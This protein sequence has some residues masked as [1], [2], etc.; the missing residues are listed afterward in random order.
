MDVGVRAV[1]TGFQEGSQ[2]VE[3]LA[4]SIDKVTSSGKGLDQTSTQASK[5]LYELM[6]GG[7][8]AMGAMR[9]LSA[10][11]MEA[12]TIIGAAA[13]VGLV[14]AIGY[15][16]SQFTEAFNRTRSLGDQLSNL[17]QR[18]GLAVETI[19]SLQVAAATSNL[20]LDSLAVGV[21]QFNRHII[22]ATKGS[23]QAAEAFDR[24][25]ISVKDS[26]GQLKSSEALLGEVADRF[27]GMEDGAAKTALAIELFGRAG[28]NMIPLLNQGSD[29]LARMQEEARLA[30]VAMSEDTAKAAQELNENLAVLK[31]YATGFWDE[32]AAP[33]VRGLAEMTRVMREAR[34]EGAG[35]FGSLFAGAEVGSVEDIDKKIATVQS[36]IK[37]LQGSGKLNG[38]DQQNLQAMYEG[39]Q[40]LYKLRG[41]AGGEG[42]EGPQTQDPGPEDQQSAARQEDQFAK[43]LNQYAAYYQKLN[44]MR[45]LSDDDYLKTLE[46]LAESAK[47]HGTAEVDMAYK[48]YQEKKRINDQYLKDFQATDAA[49]RE[50]QDGAAK[51]TNEYLKKQGEER[52]KA[53]KEQLKDINEHNLVVEKSLGDMVLAWDRFGNRIVMTRKEYELF[54]KDVE[55]TNKLLGRPEFNADVPFLGLAAGMRQVVAEILHGQIDLR[56]QVTTIWK[57]MW[58]SIVDETARVIVRGLLDG[59]LGDFR[60]VFKEIGSSIKD[61]FGDVWGF[62]KD[63]F[64]KILSIFTAESATSGAAAGTAYSTAFNASLKLTG[65][66]GGGPLSLLSNLLPSGVLANLLSTPGPSALLPIGA[67]MAQSPFNMIG[68]TTRFLLNPGDAIDKVGNVISDIGDALGFASGTDSIFTSPTLI[69]VGESGP[70]RATI[71]PLGGAAHGRDRGGVTFVFNGPT[72]LDNYSAQ[73]LGREIR[74][75]NRG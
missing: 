27:R 31:S 50:L 60:K 56:R 25:G 54:K 75:L 17:S 42:Q 45:Q 70:E 33:F 2:Q 24:I 62:V 28:A 59:L 66:S 58:N 52:A 10:S 36:R 41:I 13:G 69:R 51:A 71:S 32:I 9:G 26:G 29:G 8:E 16:V 38:F 37:A 48:V 23:G 65:G 72:M 35:F 57:T 4:K 47:G 1:V 46:G 30:G 11:A 18:T 39:L 5:S 14:G 40:R 3:G 12:T 15:A 64:L 53:E 49:E 6:G 67:Y 44:A 19:S 7:R 61:I 68:A 73:R 74:R 34:R 63:A 43:A 55:D 22:D 21:Q 20:S